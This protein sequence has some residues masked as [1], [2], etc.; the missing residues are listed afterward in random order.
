MISS[1]GQRATGPAERGGAAGPAHQA[2][3]PG[4][5]PGPWATAPGP[6]GLGARS[7]RPAPGQRPHPGASPWEGDPG[8]RDNPSPFRSG[9]PGAS[10]RKGLRGGWRTEGKSRLYR[11]ADAAADVSAAAAAHLTGT[12]R[13]GQVRPGGPDP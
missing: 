10:G 7:R 9:L 3:P 4:P 11:P 5:R 8:R 13:G 6:P 2:P 1:P 12:P